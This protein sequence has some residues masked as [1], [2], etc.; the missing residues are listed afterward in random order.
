MCRDRK[1]PYL[2]HVKEL[3]VAWPHLRYL[4]Q[5]MEV[6]TS[7]VKWE[8]FLKLGI[9][10]DQYRNQRAALTKVAVVDFSPDGDVE[11]F[12]R[13]D[14]SR[15]LLETLQEPKPPEISRLYVV[16]D[17]S[18]DMIEYLGRELD[19]DPLFFR[20]HINDYWW[21]NT[22]DPW[23]E[24]PDLDVVS[25]ERPYFRLTY[26]QPRYFKDKNSFQRAKIQAGKFN[27]LRRLDDDSEHKALF[28]S[29]R[30]IVALLRSKAS[31]WIKPQEAGTNTGF[32]GMIPRDSN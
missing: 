4:A 30:A 31:L 15:V 5:W 1:Y 29:D 28:D 2:Q 27:V 7:P 32:T 11:I 13:I 14:K 21:Y 20:E 3:S 19:I 23:V 8:Q 25:R 16:E 18:R 12:K 9:N 10:M 17:L 22:R 24:L 26:V 6:T